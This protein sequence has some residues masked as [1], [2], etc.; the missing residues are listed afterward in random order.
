ML[1]KLLNVSILALTLSGCA[2][3]RLQDVNSA[4]NRYKYIPDTIDYTKSYGQFIK[5]GGGDCEDYAN[6][7]KHILGGELRLWPNII[8]SGDGYSSH[9]VLVVDGYIL[10]NRTESI[11]PASLY[12]TYPYTPAYK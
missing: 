9:V 12:T 11:K 5:D 7:K 10:D 3:S 8:K 4:I 2:T 1:S 6:A